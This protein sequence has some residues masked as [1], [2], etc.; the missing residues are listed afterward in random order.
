MTTTVQFIETLSDSVNEMALDND[1]MPVKENRNMNDESRDWVEE[2]RTLFDRKATVYKNGIQNAGAMFSKEEEDFLHSI[3]AT[4]QEIFDF[5]EDWCD[6]GTPDPETTLAITK[7]RR[8]Y[9]FQ[10]QQGQF[11][12]NPLSE[13]EFPSR[14]ASLAG[15]EWFPRII[16]KARAKLQG[17]LPPDLMYSCGGDR[18]F[19]NKV[20]ID[21]VEFLQT[22][23]DAGDNVDD[24]VKFVTDRAKLTRSNGLGGD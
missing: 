17:K 9:L 11:P 10:E 20:N 15:L 13:S 7:L 14:S 16:E 4:P 24:I 23:W 22:V 19:L 8:D 12:G 3:G 18:R 1:H 21:P 2:F 5:V 6:D